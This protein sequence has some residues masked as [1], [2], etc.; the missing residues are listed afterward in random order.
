[1]ST[2]VD[3][4]QCLEA[5]ASDLCRTVSELS[6]ID[7]GSILFCLSRS[8]AGGTHGTYARIA[9]LRFVGGNIEQTRRRGRYMETFRLPSLDHDGRQILYLVYLLLP[10]FLRLSFEQKLETVVHELYH[11]SEACD[12]DIRRLGGRNY[13]HGHSRR[14]YNRKITELAGQYLASNPDS[15]LTDFLHLDE[16]SWLRGEFRLTGLRVPLPKARMVARHRL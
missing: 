14:A 13:A 5:L 10:R 1:V 12:G 15:R 11:I 8:R 7:T 3:L 2:E 6:H 4:S 9:P 16:E